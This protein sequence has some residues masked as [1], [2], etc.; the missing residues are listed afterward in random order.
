MGKP[1]DRPPFVLDERTPWSRTLARQQA[2]PAQSAP[3]VAPSLRVCVVWASHERRTGTRR[4]S[5]AGAGPGVAG[6]IGLQSAPPRQD[7]FLAPEAR[8]RG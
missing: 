2:A 7:R 3:A 6:V 5:R 8:G 4:G 1:E